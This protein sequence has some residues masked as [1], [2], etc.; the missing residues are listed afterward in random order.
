M[1]G[2]FPT[3]NMSLVAS[4]PKERKKKE[5]GAG[6]CVDLLDIVPQWDGYLFISGWKGGKAQWALGGVLGGQSGTKRAVAARATACNSLIW[7]HRE[8]YVL[9]TAGPL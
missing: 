1:A 7:V 9:W 5:G 2:S 4:N 8:R 3:A 6:F